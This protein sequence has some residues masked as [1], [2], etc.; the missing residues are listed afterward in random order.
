[1]ID[2]SIVIPAY[3]EQDRITP[4]L[5]TLFLFLEQ[6]PWNTEVLVVD[7]GSTDNTV[8]VVT[9]LQA[10][11]PGLLLHVQPTNQ[12]KGAAVKEGML[13]SKGKLRL[14]LDADGA[15]PPEELL[16]LLSAIERGAD[17]A[18]GSRALYSSDTTIKT[19]LHRKLMGRIFNTIVNVLVLPGIKDTQCGFKLFTHEAVE[20]LFPHQ[21]SQGFSFDVELLLLAQKGS[22]NIVEVPINWTNIRGSKVNLIADSISMILDILRFPYIHRNTRIEHVSSKKKEKA[23]PEMNGVTDSIQQL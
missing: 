3:N 10:R 13:R 8:H 22:L 12:G 14:F 19:Y 17:I 1:M 11:F 21:T 2:L 5:E 4:T 15:T 7:D 20:T 16:K 9:E 6:Q 18:I 23:S